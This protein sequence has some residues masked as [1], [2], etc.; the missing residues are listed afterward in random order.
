MAGALS[1]SMSLAR[2]ALVATICASACAVEEEDPIGGP[3]PT[4]DESAD[5]T[6]AYAPPPN[7]DD[8]ICAEL[9]ADGPCALACDPGALAEEYVPAGVC[10]VFGCTLDDGR[11]IHVHA[12]HPAD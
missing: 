9:P 11:E 1:V 12:C 5:V 10:A 7:G 4:I 8:E 2:L 3:D 6:Q